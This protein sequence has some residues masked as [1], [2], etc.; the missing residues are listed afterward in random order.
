MSCGVGHRRDSDPELLWCGPAAAALILSLSWELMY[1]ASAALKSKKQN[2]T[3][4]PYFYFFF[5]PDLSKHS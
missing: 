4:K 5:P 3:K 1:A 2:K